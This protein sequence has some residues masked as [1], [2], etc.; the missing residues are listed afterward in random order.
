M[1]ISLPE[2][3]AMRTNISSLC[4]PHA[5]TAVSG[6]RDNQTPFLG[7]VDGDY[8]GEVASPGYHNGRGAG[9][10]PQVWRHLHTVVT[11]IPHLQ[12][13]RG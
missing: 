7:E 11:D 3:S 12:D 8:A 1:L 10:R 6:C 9:H 5:H 4:G 13:P 2:L